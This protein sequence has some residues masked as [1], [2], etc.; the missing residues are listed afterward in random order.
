M[1][2][3]KRFLVEIKWWNG[4]GYDSTVDEY[5]TRGKA[6]GASE[7]LAKSTNPYLVMIMDKNHPHEYVCAPIP[8]MDRPRPVQE[9]LEV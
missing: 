2:K 4:H 9:V 8:G 6:F 1:N 3:P 5:S 7:A